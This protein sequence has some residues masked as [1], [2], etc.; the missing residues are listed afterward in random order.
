MSIVSKPQWV[1]RE[2]D[3]R[4]LPGAWD[5]SPLPVAPRDPPPPTS[6]YR[7]GATTP[8]SRLAASGRCEGGGQREADGFWL[9]GTGCAV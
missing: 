6:Q 7:P 4:V 9:Q 2:T 3:V 5:V 8:T 1:T